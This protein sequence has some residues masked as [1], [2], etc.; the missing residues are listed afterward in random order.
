MV[1]TRFSW[2]LPI[3]LGFYAVRYPSALGLPIVVLF[4]RKMLFRCNTCGV[5]RNT[6]SHGWF[7]LASSTSCFFLL[8]VLIA[9]LHSELQQWFYWYLPSELSLYR[10]HLLQKNSIINENNLLLTKISKEERSRGRRKLLCYCVKKGRIPERMADGF[11]MKSQLPSHQLSP[12][13][14]THSTFRLICASHPRC[15]FE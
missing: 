13:R 8:V 7:K 6:I 12:T 3:I 10:H 4:T 2:K 9:A 5:H 1:I 14:T 15:D 11:D